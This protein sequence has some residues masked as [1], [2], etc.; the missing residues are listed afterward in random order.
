MKLTALEYE[1]LL[2]SRPAL[3]KLNGAVDPHCN[4]RA[5]ALMEHSVRHE[6]L[7][8]SESKEALG[9]RV[10]L[11]ITSVRKR[12]CDTDNIAAKFFTDFCRYCGALESDAP[13]KTKIE[14]QQRKPHPGETERTIIEIFEQI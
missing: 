4:P 10:L 13:D 7:A 3:A 1:E 12:F 6:P 9:Q 11:R 5:L 8:A 14:I 2:R